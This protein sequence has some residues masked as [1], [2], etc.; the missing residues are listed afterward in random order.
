MKEVFGT[1]KPIIGVLHMHALPTDPKFDA[2]TGVQGVLE[3]ARADLKAYQEGGIDGILFCNE[4][5]IPYT[6][7]VKP[8]TI[9]WLVLL[10]N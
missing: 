6:S 8:V 3:A 2:A 7:D 5:S 4:F 1:D 9:A 10:G